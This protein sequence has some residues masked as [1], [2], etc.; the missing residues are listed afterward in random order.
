[1]IMFRGMGITHIVAGVVL[2]VAQAIG[3]NMGPG[4]TNLIIESQLFGGL[5]MAAIGF[6]FKL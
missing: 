5:F 3:V 1:M 4:D 6:K 2:C